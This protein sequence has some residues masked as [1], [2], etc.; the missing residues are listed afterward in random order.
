MQA[1]TSVP[2][3][4][5]I[6]Q[7][8]E[9]QSKRHQKKA[10]K[11]HYPSEDI[12]EFKAKEVFDP[13]T[14]IL[15]KG[16]LTV[17]GQGQRP[18]YCHTYNYSHIHESGNG[19]VKTFKTCKMWRCP[20]CY[21][22]KVDSETFDKAVL[23]EC[24][25][26]VTGDRPFRYV[27]SMPPKKALNLTLK[28]LKDFRRNVKERAKRQGVT[29]G[30]QIFHPFRLKK[31]VQE[32]IR[33]LNG[34]DTTSGGFWS[35]ILQ[36]SNIPKINAY[37]DT[38]Y[39]TWRD[40]SNLSFHIHGLGFP[41]HQ[42]ITGDKNVVLTKLQ[43]K[44]GTYTLDSVRDVTKHIR[45]L[46]THCGVLVNT[47]DDDS[48]IK[49]SVPFGDL[50]GWKPEEYLTPE[51]IKGIRLAVLDILNEKRTKPYSVNDKGE[52]CYLGDEVTSDEKLKDLGYSRIIER[53][54]YDAF[55]AE[56]T[57]AWLKS[58]KNP[59]NAAFVEYLLSEYSRVLNDK[60]IPQKLRCLFL[61]DLRDPPDSFEVI[62][63]N[64]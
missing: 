55:S 6:T 16:N 30:L 43:K 63:L 11:L 35:Y 57:D 15:N 49:P 23:I 53:V 48:R 19:A 62:T 3:W 47:H 64:V 33:V 18:D 2:D 60:T 17:P 26:L 58:I 9:K 37:L 5:Q 40:C 10:S 32:A 4:E 52:L 24:Y 13:K 44:D 31:K 28:E 36:P 42:K 46:L 1:L 21:H 56:C 8:R 38:D 34:D 25:A 29:A 22:F 27:G 50:H 45:Y 20:S 39:K 61:E 7:D 54:P 12:S 59:D 51:E 14:S 41:G